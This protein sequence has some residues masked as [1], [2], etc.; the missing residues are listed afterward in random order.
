MHQRHGEESISIVNSQENNEER[1]YS[2]TFSAS[3]YLHVAINMRPDQRHKRLP[4]T[5]EL[6]CPHAVD[7]EHFAGGQRRLFG[8]LD[9]RRVALKT[10]Y[11]GMFSSSAIALRNLRSLA[12]SL[13]S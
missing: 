4:E 11:G 7:A 1:N 13:R 10:T 3:D 8:H 2:G 12:N 9:K 5:L 6:A